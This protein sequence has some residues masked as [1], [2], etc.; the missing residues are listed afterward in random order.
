MGSQRIKSSEEH[1]S[2]LCDQVHVLAVQESSYA[3]RRLRGHTLHND[4][5]PYS[6]L[7]TEEALEL[8]SGRS[9]GALTFVWHKKNLIKFI[10]ILGLKGTRVMELL[11]KNKILGA[12]VKYVPAK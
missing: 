7:A 2:R 4:Y 9:N 3:V 1:V 12:P 8:Q 10:T 5:V 11:H 6:V